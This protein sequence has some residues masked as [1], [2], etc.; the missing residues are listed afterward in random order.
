[1]RYA[2]AIVILVLCGITIGI[3]AFLIPGIRFASKM[4]S[5][6]VARQREI[7]YHINHTP[8][9]DE[10]RKFAEQQ[11][12]E[13]SITET[14]PLLFRGNNL[15][16]PTSLQTM[17]CTGVAIFADRVR[18]EF[19]GPFLHF[20]LDVF[21]KGVPGNGIKELAEGVWYYSEDGRVPAR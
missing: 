3:A 14:A 19:G 21:N 2:K 5:E 6:T 17:K 12:Q 4:Q 20:G 11:R 10:V 18:L 15:E 16:L 9:A 8:L 13:T 7:F 1:M